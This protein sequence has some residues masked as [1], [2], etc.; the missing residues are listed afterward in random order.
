ML[1]LSAFSLALLAA[2]ALAD[3]TRCRH[4]IPAEEAIRI[5]RDAGIAWV[6]KLECDDGRSDVEGRDAADRQIE[7]TVNPAD[8]R[9]IRV[10]R[11]R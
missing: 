10:E 2:P 6:G 11:G 9:V 4:G 8:G 7:V 3:G 1:V 5:A